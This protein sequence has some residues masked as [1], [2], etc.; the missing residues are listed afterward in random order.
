[1]LHLFQAA[2]L[3]LQLVPYYTNYLHFKTVYDFFV[4]FL[5]WLNDMA[6]ITCISNRGGEDVGEDIYIIRQNSFKMHLRAE[7]DR[8]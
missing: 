7:N 6:I 3:A 1:M 8:T 5:K 4:A 2:C